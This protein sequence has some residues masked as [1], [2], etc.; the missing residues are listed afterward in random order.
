MGAAILETVTYNQTFPTFV[1]TYIM[2]QISSKLVS[3]EI[4]STAAVV[5]VVFGT[6]I[7]VF[8]RFKGWGSNRGMVLH[9]FKKA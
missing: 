8:K 1:F 3:F 5:A 7:V 4:L 2:S 6:G 9:I